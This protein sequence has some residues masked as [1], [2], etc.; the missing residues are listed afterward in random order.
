MAAVDRPWRAVCVVGLALLC[1]G[2]V[3]AGQSHGEAIYRRAC[4][5]CHGLDG[6]GAPRETVGFEVPLP[7]FT[8]CAFTSAEPT[9]D[10][11][12]V[13]HDG[14]PA[15]AFDRRMPAF[16][17]ALSVG[18]IV[19]ALDYIRDFCL[20]SQAWP[21]G[22]LNLPRPLVTEKAYPE[23]EL[24]MTTS[25]QSGAATVQV[26]Y[27]RRVGALGQ[28]EVS[29]PLAAQDD[30]SGRRRLGLGDLSIGFKRVLVHS[31]AA[32]RI[33][34]LGGEVMLPTGRQSLGLGRT[35]V[36]EP[37]VALGQVLAGSA[38]W[39]A[40]A[41]AEL[42]A[43]NGGDREVFGR[44]AVGATL[45]YGRFG[46]AWSPMLE[47]LASRPLRAGAPVRWAAVPQLQVTLSRR[48][49]IMLSVGTRVPLDS[50][51]KG[52]TRLMTYFLW[53]WVDGGL[54]EGW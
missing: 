50:R 41:G 32:G 8:D 5:A 23:N 13:A 48:Q 1:G 29:V 33:V 25:V 12:A 24:V 3:A 46:R 22:E 42:A 6:R 39:H 26:L 11:L 15:R 27:E 7:D 16:G 4:A 9:A 47:L 10:W 38:F 51:D 37:F 54:F 19:S 43:T 40:Q 20:D 34:S 18:E 14:G 44:T 53:D 35:A 31:L 52:G 2:G 17:E 36:I 30:A 49:H 21:R 28:L 45:E